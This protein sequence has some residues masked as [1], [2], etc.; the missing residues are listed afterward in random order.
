MGVGYGIRE[1]D[2]G[3]VF[4]CCMDLGFLMKGRGLHYLS[5]DR[6]ATPGEGTMSCMPHFFIK[7]LIAQAEVALRH[8]G[9][10]TWEYFLNLYYSYDSKINT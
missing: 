7:L 5:E 3:V 10:G 1:R 4:G 8:Y 6:W 9:L 2:C